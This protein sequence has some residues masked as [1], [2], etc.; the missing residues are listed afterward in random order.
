MLPLDKSGEL[1]TV[2]KEDLQVKEPPVDN[3]DASQKWSLQQAAAIV[4]PCGEIWYSV[5]G[6]L[7]HLGVG[8]AD[9]H[10]ESSIEKLKEHGDPINRAEKGPANTPSQGGK[11]SRAQSNNKRSAK[12]GRRIK[13]QKFN[14]AEDTE[15]LDTA[16]MD[17]QVDH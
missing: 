13:R 15:S 14:Q 11:N 12:K 16:D 6:P 9:W 10:S 1:I 3:I 7:S 17:D 2:S 5:T 8:P 4:W